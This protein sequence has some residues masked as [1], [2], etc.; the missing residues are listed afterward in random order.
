MM[1]IY[2]DKKGD[3]TGYPLDYDNVKYLVNGEENMNPEEWEKLKLAKIENW[4]CPA[5]LDEDQEATPGEIIKN[6]DGII[7]RE[8]I[9]ETI[10]VDE[11]IRRWILGPRQYRLITSDWTIGLDSPFSED[12]KEKWKEYRRQLRDMTDTIDIENLRSAG[13][14]EWPIPPSDIETKWTVAVH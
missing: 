5:Q 3:P 10:T 13:D 14:I 6:V 9:I 11:K 8:W 4:Q 2:L 1:F 12:E 7:E